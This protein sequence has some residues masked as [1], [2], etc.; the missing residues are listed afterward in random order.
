MSKPPFSGLGYH[1]LQYCI[2]Q[3]YTVYTLYRTVLQKVDTEYGYRYG[4]N[5]IIQYTIQ[6]GWSLSARYRWGQDQT[7]IE[8]GGRRVRKSRKEMSGLCD[9][10]MSGPLMGRMSGV[11]VRLL[12]M[13]DAP[14]FAIIFRSVPRS[15]L[16]QLR[17][18]PFFVIRS[19]LPSSRPFHFD[20]ARE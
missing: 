16:H 3:L 9:S 13:L 7:K 19:A 18:V 1:F 20:R 6:Y 10:G 15:A 11:F 2:E 8:G 17:L 14:P 4:Y 5:C 12:H